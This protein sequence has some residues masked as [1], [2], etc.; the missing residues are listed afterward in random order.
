MIA[1]S[2]QPRDKS[3]SRTKNWIEINDDSS[4]KSESNNEIRFKTSMLDSSLSD[5]SYVW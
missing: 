5:Y 2:I 3:K 1:W 4:G